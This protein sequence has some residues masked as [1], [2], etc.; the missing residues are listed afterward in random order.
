MA[1][2]PK[3][4]L[5]H[6]P[7]TD[8]ANHRRYCANWSDACIA[9]GY[10]PITEELEVFKFRGHAIH[11]DETLHPSKRAEG[12]LMVLRVAFYW[13]LRGACMA[14]WGGWRA[15]P[16][17]REFVSQQLPTS[18]RDVVRVAEDHPIEKFGTRGAESE[19]A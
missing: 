17:W 16:T 11:R 1:I 10:E 18:L 13:K 7:A 15:L 19:P 14:R 5:Q 2:C 4:L 9:L 8:K 6:D 12:F 3:C